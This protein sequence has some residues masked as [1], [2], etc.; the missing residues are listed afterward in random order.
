MR[1]FLKLLKMTIA[2]LVH[3][4]SFYVMLTIG[5]L[6]VLLLRGCY[7]Q[8]YTVNGRQVAATAVAWHASI[9]AFH[10]IAA[11]ALLIAMFLS[12]GALKRDRDDGS[13][14]YILSGPV[15]RTQYVLAKIAGQWAVSFLF[16]FVLHATIVVITYF[17]T[18]GVMPG[19]LTASLVCSLN[20]LFMVVAVS[21]L[22]LML[23]VFASG[24]LSVCV[25]AFSLVS[26]SFFQIIQKTGVSP[27][28]SGP[29]FWR[30]AWPKTASLQYFSATLIDH[31]DFK[32]MGPL[33]PLV[34]VLLWTAVLGIILIWRFRREDL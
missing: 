4:K 9:I 22:S 7:K 16:M 32:G 11:G 12:L 6:F 33:H 25:A 2:D 18:G 1:N 23:P 27:S 10:I 17:N 13:V 14:S 20:I 28:F 26:D 8:D 5:V 15:T 3:H 31:S 24:L 34:N 19:Y 21:L 29:S 30:I